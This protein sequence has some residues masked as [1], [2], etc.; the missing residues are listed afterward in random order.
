MSKP[1]FQDLFTWSGRRNRKSFILQQLAFVGIIIAGVI[2]SGVAALVIPVVGG[3][4]YF[5][6]IILGV[7]LLVSSVAAIAQRIRDVGYPGWWAVLMLV[8]FLNLAFTV[9]LWVAPSEQGEN[10]F[11]PALV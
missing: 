10:K 4:L 3:A 7:I 6:T 9:A 5:L 8:P 11:G 2:L 1:I